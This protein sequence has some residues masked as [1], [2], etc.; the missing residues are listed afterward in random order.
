MFIKCVKINTFSFA[1]FPRPSYQNIIHNGKFTLPLNAIYIISIIPL[2]PFIFL[3]HPSIP[4]IMKRSQ[5]I[6]FPYGVFPGVFHI[7]MHVSWFY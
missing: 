7:P 6:G 3:F 4:A 1:P 5:K 2:F